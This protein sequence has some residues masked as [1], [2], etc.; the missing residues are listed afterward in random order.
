MFSKDTLAG[1]SFAS[2]VRV[3]QMRL[4]PEWFPAHVLLW[5][6]AQLDDTIAYNAYAAVS[7]ES[8]IYNIIPP[9][10]QAAVIR[11]MEAD[12]RLITS[13]AREAPPAGLV[14]AAVQAAGDAS[15]AI[16][17]ALTRGGST[18]ERGD[19]VISKPSVFTSKGATP[20]HLAAALGRVKAGLALL[21]AGA[22][23]TALDS[24]RAVR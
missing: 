7:D 11:T 10:F 2:R 4:Q 12:P 19:L 6:R 9:S 20:L 17:E 1:P 8:P 13:L 16:A 22:D 21:R 23:V 14:W 15:A 24:V 3:F 18:N 5:A